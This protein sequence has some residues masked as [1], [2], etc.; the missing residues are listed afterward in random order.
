M[1]LTVLINHDSTTLCGL[2]RDG[3]CTTWK[4]GFDSD[5]QLHELQLL[6]IKIFHFVFSF[7]TI[8]IS[9][10]NKPPLPAQ[11]GLK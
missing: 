1:I 9:H 11:M 4:F 5:P 7:F 6:V 2:I 8:I 3:L 10:L